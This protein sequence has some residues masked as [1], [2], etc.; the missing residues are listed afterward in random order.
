VVAH[1]LGRR[2]LGVEIDHEYCL[3]AAKR[4]M[5]AEEDNSI[6]GYSGGYFWERNTD[7]LQRMSDVEVVGEEEIFDEI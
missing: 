5:L 1:K 7:R 4:L 3:W 6:Q 2:Y